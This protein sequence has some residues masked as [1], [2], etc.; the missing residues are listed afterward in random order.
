MKVPSQKSVKGQFNSQSAQIVE[1]KG[2]KKLKVCKSVHFCWVTRK[3]KKKKSNYHTGLYHCF[4]GTCMTATKQSILIYIARFL[5][6]VLKR[7]F[8]LIEK[9]NNV[10]AV[11]IWAEK[12]KYEKDTP[13]VFPLQTDTRRKQANIEAVPE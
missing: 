10:V 8:G 3:R 11:I 6:F 5:E 9:K 4:S 1:P 7:L 2:N 13:V 12:E